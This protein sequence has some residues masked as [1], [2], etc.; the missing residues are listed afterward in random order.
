MTLIEKIKTFNSPILNIEGKEHLVVSALL[1]EFEK[2]Q[3]LPDLYTRFVTNDIFR[4]ILLEVATN[5]YKHS[6]PIGELWDQI[7][8]PN[9]TRIIK[10]KILDVCP[11][12]SLQRIARYERKV[13]TVK[14]ELSDLNLKDRIGYKAYMFRVFSASDDMLFELK[15]NRIEEFN[16]DM[17]KA[18]ISS[19]FTHVQD[20]LDDKSKDY[21]IPL[22]NR[23]SLQNTILELFDSCYLQFEEV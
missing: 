6:D 1:D 11:D 23:D 14:L 13:A 5:N 18:W 8:K 15:D 21:T 2:K 19:L 9:D 20:V 16:E 4:R 7:D 17:I 12:F 22:K 10:E 3:T